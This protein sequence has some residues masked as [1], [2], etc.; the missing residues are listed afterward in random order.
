MK[1]VVGQ[2]CGRV[3]QP[4]V[5]ERAA[6]CWLRHQGFP[7]NSDIAIAIAVKKGMC[8]DVSCK[9]RA[10]SGTCSPSSRFQSCRH[11]RRT[12]S[13]ARSETAARVHRCRNRNPHFKFLS[14]GVLTASCGVKFDHG[15]PAV[16][17][18]TDVESDD[19]KAKNSWGFSRCEGD[20]VRL[21]RHLVCS[22]VSGCQWRGF[23]LV[24]V[25]VQRMRDESERSYR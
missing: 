21:F 6:V 5:F 8:T 20:C 25:R 3:R 9:C 4:C 2:I 7:F 23:H 18:N 11:R 12:G 10:T 19:W 13:V 17:D 22:T 16:E 24:V 1:T 15:V 14:T